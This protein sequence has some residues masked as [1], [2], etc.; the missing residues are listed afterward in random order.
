MRSL[1]APAGLLILCANLTA[2]PVPA[3]GPRLAAAAREQLHAEAL[4]YAHQLLGVV[5]QVALSYYRPVPRAELFHAA[6]S[7][8]YAAAR[9]P[10]PAT[11]RADLKRLDDVAL[12]NFLAR[13]RE[14]LGPCAELHEHAA[15]L[16][17]CRALMRS[18]DAYCAVVTEDRR[19]DLPW[20]DQPVGIGLELEDNVGAGP[21]RVRKVHPGGP[22]QK[23]GLR[24]GDVI[25]HIDARPVK[26]GTTSAQASGLLHR[27]GP[28][29]DSGPDADVLDAP[30]PRPVRLTVARRGGEPRPVVLEPQGGRPESVLGALRRDNNAWDYLADRAN[31]VAH[32]RITG[33]NRGTADELAGVLARLDNEGARGLVLDLRWCPG[34]FLDEAVGVAGLFLDDG[35]LVTTIK[36][37][38]DRE[39]PYR[40][41]QP[42]R[43][44]RLPLVVLVNGQT[45]GGA[46]LI[47]AAL[48]DHGRAP[49]AGQRTRG[50]ATVQTALYAN[51]PG[52]SLRLTSGEFVRKGGKNLHRR[53]ESRPR[54]DWGVRPAPALECRLSTGLERQLKEWWEQQTLR[55]GASNHLLPL[56]DPA[57]DPQRQAAVRAVVELLKKRDGQNEVRKAERTKTPARLG[58]L[59]ILP[60]LPIRLDNYGPVCSS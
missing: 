43:Y 36:G 12:V 26:E 29:F 1:L 40:N 10:V 49:V 25:T 20:G 15:L 3:G 45:S 32:V 28:A 5:N 14:S 56:D 23:A 41:S 38:D 8:L 19:T 18:L 53:P 13:A 24:P 58:V 27:G 54:D 9:R 48:Q 55:P 52:A 4:N 51:I 33:L 47:A 7:G 31:G 59:P 57:E 37:R 60:I 50:K 22:A 17:S 11:L 35:A 46:E 6:L 2:A 42:R 34:G 39:T 30:P 44:L 16:A 21:L